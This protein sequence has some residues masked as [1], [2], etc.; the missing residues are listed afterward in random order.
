MNSAWCGVERL[1]LLMPKCRL[2]GLS[3][4]VLTSTGAGLNRR[5]APQHRSPA[6]RSTAAPLL[7]PT[8][9]EEITILCFSER[10][11][12]LFFLSLFAADDILRVNN[13]IALGFSEKG[14]S[15]W[16]IYTMGYF[17]APSEA[18]SFPLYEDKRPLTSLPYSAKN[19]T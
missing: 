17:P 1:D 12:G 18:G 10:V 19:L 4:T 16:S 13:V 8:P 9:L 2:L 3:L 15:T 11:A 6:A 5:V 14:G 7:H